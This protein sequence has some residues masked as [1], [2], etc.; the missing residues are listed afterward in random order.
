M[1]NLESVHPLIEKIAKK[2]YSLNSMSLIFHTHCT[3]IAHH[4]F[5]V[6]SHLLHAIGMLVPGIS[7]IPWC[8]RNVQQLYA[9]GNDLLQI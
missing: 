8:F 4:Y 2:E 6:L 5:S 9:H 3:L 1:Q 7:E